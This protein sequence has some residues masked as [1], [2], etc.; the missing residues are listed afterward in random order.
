[1]ASTIHTS[2]R[3][4]LTAMR[5]L[6]DQIDG[7]LIDQVADVLFNTWE[8]DGQVIVFGNGGSAST[9]SHFVTDIVK[10]AAANG[11]RPLR[12]LSLVDNCGITTAVANDADYDETFCFPMSVYARPGDL[13]IAISCSGNS[14]N[15]VNAARWAGEHGLQLVGL[16]GFDGG[17]LGRLANLHVNIPSENYGLIED[18]HLSIG[19]MICQI[20]KSRVE[21]VATCR[22]AVGQ[23]SK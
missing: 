11:H 1:M 20:L 5:R 13:A 3:D 14:P 2:A 17:T 16:T 19:H 10:T 15:V 7:T 18:M 23:D 21:Q 12:A 8:V 22:D 6:L 9:S 4:Y